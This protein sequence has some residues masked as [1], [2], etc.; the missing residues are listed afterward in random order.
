MNSLVGLIQPERF[1]FTNIITISTY[2]FDPV[3]AR[4]LAQVVAESYKDNRRKELNRQIDGSIDF[5]KGQIKETED[6]LHTAQMEFETYSTR[7]EAIIPYYNSGGI[8]RDLVDLSRAERAD[9]KE[10]PIPS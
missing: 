5:I 1:E 10:N 7:S 2:A 9:E 4:D 3:R 6:S 8:A